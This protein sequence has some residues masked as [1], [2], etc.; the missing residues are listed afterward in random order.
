M[1]S[2]RPGE[3]IEVG[4]VIVIGPLN[5]ASTV[6]HHASQ[7]FS[8]NVTAFLIHLRQ[9]GLPDANTT[10]EIVRETLL[11]RSGEVVHP[12]DPRPPGFRRVVI[13]SRP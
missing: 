5:I 12:A 3:T 2:T 9:Q 1:K 13:G 4:G 8:R 7:M 10:D 6:A 11:T